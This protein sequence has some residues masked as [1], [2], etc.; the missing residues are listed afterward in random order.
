MVEVKGRYVI[1]TSVKVQM[2]CAHD[3]G[4]VWGEKGPTVGPRLQEK[5]FETPSVTLII[6]PDLRNAVQYCSKLGRE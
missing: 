2:R 5:P 6:L 4:G 1:Y 3:N